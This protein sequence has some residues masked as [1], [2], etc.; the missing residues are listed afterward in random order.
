MVVYQNSNN[1]RQDMY[2]RVFLFYTLPFADDISIVDAL[3]DEVDFT[4]GSYF[5][6]DEN[7]IPKR[8]EV[9]GCKKEGNRILS[10]C[11]PGLQSVPRG[12]WR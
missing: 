4:A 11:H 1:G 6:P 2:C 7:R 9:P 5:C 10:P 3:K 8:S 12:L